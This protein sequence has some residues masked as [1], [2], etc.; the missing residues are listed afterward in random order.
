MANNTNPKDISFFTRTLWW[1]AG[2]TPEILEKYPSE[3]AKFSAIGMTIAM[4]CIVAFVSG[5]SAAWYFSS[6]IVAAFCFG[7]FWALLIFC[8][9]RALVVTMKKST[10]PMSG[11]QKLLESLKIIVPRAVLAILVALLMSIPLELIVFEDLIVAELPNYESKKLEDASKTGYEATRK[12]EIG[13]RVDN[14]KKEHSNVQQERSV[15]EKAKVEADAKVTSLENSIRN[16]KAQKNNPNTAR[17][18]TAVNEV[19]KADAALRNVDLT[20][21]EKANLRVKRANNN[22]IM[23]EEKKKWNS[24]IETKIQDVQK[25]LAV[26]QNNA[27]NKDKEYTD[28]KERENEISKIKTA[29]IKDET[30]ADKN[31]AIKVNKVDSAQKNTNKFLLHYSVLEYAVHAKIME[32]VPVPKIRTTRI[33][34]MD[35]VVVNVDENQEANVVKSEV[36][37]ESDEVEYR[38][39][40]HYRNVQAL[41]MLWLIRILFFVFE[42]MPTVVKAVS[43]PGPYE[44]E[45]EAQD[46]Q[47]AKFFTSTSYR[48]HIQ[49]MLNDKLQHERQLEEDRR[50]AEKNLHDHLLTKIQDAQKEVAIQAIDKWRTE[51]LN[52]TH[53]GHRI[54]PQSSASTNMS[55]NNQTVSQ[56]SPN[57]TSGNHQQATTQV[58]NDNSAANNN[59]QDEF[60]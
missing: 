29:A 32:K 39:E 52:V 31:V 17:Y 20:D 8:I 23:N 19:H 34:Q 41:A 26:A 18:R 21:S 25:K 37:T 3:Y 9:D 14:L 51:Q 44:R 16:L 33:E 42:M 4:T 35:S 13:K 24:E 1:I 11:T 43:K 55:S 30:E 45:C 59:Y 53:S 47:M 10:K 7:L 49:T 6:S 48:D 2:A 27:R 5:M 54:S 22:S 58:L 60:D 50:N 15:A 38:E 46:E 12:N 56:L 57:Q 36:D 28:A 40:W